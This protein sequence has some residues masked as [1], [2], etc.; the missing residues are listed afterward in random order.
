MDDLYNY[1]ECKR[2][3]SARC[4]LRKNCVEAD[5]PTF[6]K[7]FKDFDYDTCL[8]YAQEHC[9]TRKIGWDESEWNSK[10]VEECTEAILSLYPDHC[11]DLRKADD[12]TEWTILGDACVFIEEP[13]DRESDVVGEDSDTNGVD[14]GTR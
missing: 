8:T 10:N 2:I 5:D 3:E 14:G 6:D 11:K 9:R 12:E 1:A 7:N 13:K 4:E